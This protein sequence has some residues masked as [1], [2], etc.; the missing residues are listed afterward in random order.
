M[1]TSSKSFQLLR[2]FVKQSELVEHLSFKNFEMTKE[3]IEKITALIVTLPQTQVKSFRF[4]RC[5]FT[6]DNLPYI[7]RAI[8]HNGYLEF[9]KIESCN[10]TDKSL[11][12]FAGLWQYVPFLEYF[13]LTHCPGVK[14][15][16]YFS[17]FLEKI[18]VDL[19]LVE[20]DLSHNS[21]TEKISTFLIDELFT[22]KNLPLKTLNLSYNDFTPHENWKVYQIFIQS[23]IHETCDLIMEPYPINIQYFDRISKSQKSTTLELLRGDI[24]KRQFKRMLLSKQEISKC[25]EVKEELNLSIL[26]K[27]PLEQ[28]FNL[29]KTI[30][31]LE[32]S[33]PVQYVENATLYMRE[34]MI[35]AESLEDYYSFYHAKE[36]ALMI[37]MNRKD[38][39]PKANVMKNTTDIFTQKLTR[40]FSFQIPENQINSD[41]EKLIDIAMKRDYRGDAID[42]LLYLKHKR[43]EKVNELIT[44]NIDSNYIELKLMQKDPFYI[45]KNDEDFKANCKK[46]VTAGITVETIIS[47]H[48]AWVDYEK[49]S[50]IT[51]D[52]LTLMVEEFDY[53]L[54]RLMDKLEKTRFERTKFMLA[55]SD[56]HEFDIC[57]Q[58]ILLRISKTVCIYRHYKGKYIQDNKSI[59]Q[60]A[61]QYVLSSALNPDGPEVSDIVSRVLDSEDHSIFDLSPTTSIK[62]KDT[63]K[64]GTKSLTGGTKDGQDKVGEDEEDEGTPLKRSAEADSEDDFGDNSKKKGKGEDSI[65]VSVKTPKGKG[66]KRMSVFTENQEESAAGDVEDTAKSDNMGESGRGGRKTPKM[67]RRKRPPPLKDPEDL[68]RMVKLPFSISAT[69]YKTGL[70][71]NGYIF[72]ICRLDFEMNRTTMIVSL[73]KNLNKF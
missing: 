56:T 45:L 38:I 1:M 42:L 48:Q 63:T 10:I 28:L 11:R 37:G 68:E 58:D 64:K 41:L 73:Q 26:A 19:Q 50:Q 39:E 61:K 15:E 20:L 46:L 3:Q 69:D 22:V 30:H 16:I 54:E 9:L 52:K 23:T 34:T 49:V 70:R 53:T 31:D 36:G 14:A 24:K 51:K 60:K 65:S 7:G 2:H 32:H 66:K 44:R 5:N 40:I 67:K 17:S 72:K 59:V 13:S 18:V 43:D 29:C 57:E 71:I 12:F 21:L 6:D 27:K 35:Q 4:L 8:K 47:L 25:K 33:F 55:D 62:D